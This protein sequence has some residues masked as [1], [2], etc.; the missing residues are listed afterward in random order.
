MALIASGKDGI[1]SFESG[2]RKASHSQLIYQICKIQS[3]AKLLTHREVPQQLRLL[4]APLLS[5]VLASRMNC[6]AIVPSAGL[7]KN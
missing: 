1:H 2:Q 3:A 5:V 6:S 4:R 7:R